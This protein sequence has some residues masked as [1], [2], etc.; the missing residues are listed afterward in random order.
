MIKVDNI[1]YILNE[2]AVF[3]PHWCLLTIRK[4]AFVFR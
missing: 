1:E 3:L 4:V 2:D